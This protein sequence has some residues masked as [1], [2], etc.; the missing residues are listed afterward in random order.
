MLVDNRY[1]SSVL[2]M[3]MTWWVGPARTLPPYRAPRLVTKQKRSDKVM[4]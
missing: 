4:T 3:D 1:G 2:V